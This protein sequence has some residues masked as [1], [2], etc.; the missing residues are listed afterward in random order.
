MKLNAKWEAALR[1]ELQHAA[2][3]IRLR[4]KLADPWHRA[5]TCCVVAQQIRARRVHQSPTRSPFRKQVRQADWNAALK[6]A[7]QE[8]RQRMIRRHK[9]G[10]WDYALKL[11]L[12][13]LRLRV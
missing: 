7:A 12:T 8:A 2:V 1:E 5:L 11:K 10:G 6:I 3:R 4:M 13:G 9:K